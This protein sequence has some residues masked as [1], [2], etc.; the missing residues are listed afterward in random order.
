MKKFLPLLLLTVM[1]MAFG[2][3]DSKAAGANITNL[4]TQHNQFHNGN[5]GMFVRF[6][7]NVSGLRG[8]TVKAQVTL[9]KSN[10]QKIK[11][12]N[13]TTATYT[14]SGT[15][16]YDLTNYN[17]MWVFFPHSFNLPRGR[18]DCYALVQIIS[19]SGKVLTSR[20]TTFWYNKS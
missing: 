8:K 13:G 12:L 1:L 9:Y 10:G 15:P 18:T 4:Y 16:A 19:P 11:F 17:G 5:N 20:K 14:L 6:D 2:I 3:E 7:Y